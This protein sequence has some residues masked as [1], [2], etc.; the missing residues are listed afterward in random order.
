MKRISFCLLLVYLYSSVAV[1]SQAADT[2]KAAPATS[3]LASASVASRGVEPLSV[4]VD[5]SGG[6]I[7]KL[8]EALAKVEGVS[9]N[10]IFNGLNRDDAADFAKLEFPPFS[11]RNASVLG[12]LEVVS[13]LLEPR[14]FRL[15]PIGGPNPNSWICTVQKT[16]ALQEKSSSAQT[17]FL[18]YQL[19]PFLQSQ[20]V[21]DIV[22]ALHAAWE[23]DPSHAPDL[24]H[25][26]FH[27]GTSILL[28]SG[29]PEAINITRNLLVELKR[30][31]EQKNAARTLES[32]QDKK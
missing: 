9:F 23:L 18:S 29:P 10:I 6:P 7:N 12:I 2:P 27:P 13:D 24:L 26:K 5:F 22:G 31:P 1:G 15:K 30:Q 32:T 16:P 17:Q 19:A 4:N 11:L 8:V 28:V 3:S 25:V 20:S 14:G 21:D